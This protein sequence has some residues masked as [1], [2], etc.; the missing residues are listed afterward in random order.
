MGVWKKKWDFLDQMTEKQN[1][2]NQKS[3]EL[4]WALTRD[5][6]LAVEKKDRKV[7]L[8]EEKILTAESHIKKA[9][10]KDKQQRL[11]KKAI[12]K[13]IQ[14]KAA[15]V[16][17]D[18]AKMKEKK[19]IYDEMNLKSKQASRNIVQLKRNIEKKQK[20]MKEV[21][22]EIVK[23]KNGKCR[24]YEEKRLA[25]ANQRKK[26]T[27]EIVSLNAQIETSANHLTHLNADKRSKEH[28][29]QNAKC[30]ANS[31]K[32]KIQQRKKDISRLESG[33]KNK[34]AAFGEFM[35]RLVDE[36]QRCKKFNKKPIGP[37]GAFISLKENLP[38]EMNAVLEGELGG[39]MWAF[40][41][42]SSKD[43]V[44]LFDICKRLNISN[45]V[46]IMTS[47]FSSQQYNVSKTKVCSSSYT[48][49]LDCMEISN[50]TVFNILVDTLQLEKII[51]ISS[52]AEAQKILKNPET[53]PKNLKYAVVEAKYQYY[54][55]P[56]YKS[57]YKGYRSQNMLMASFDDLIAGI[58]KEVVNYEKEAAAA[59]EKYLDLVN[60]A[61]SSLKLSD[62]EEKKIV[63]IRKKLTEKNLLDQTLANEEYAEKPA[64]IKLD[65]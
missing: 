15:T 12:E 3:S 52:A 27:E 1:E 44:V 61:N 8:I 39:M 14:E 49:L 30:E 7:K 41:C 4:A 55:A 13:E 45:K 24:E 51:A 31:L 46:T 34:L 43:Q 42:N 50:P 56:N 17:N 54:P 25:R 58:K 35:P 21:G 57:Y 28:A 10:D 53:V 23:Y 18:N 16:E 36:I 32:V 47:E 11:D 65:S 6:D 20:M 19:K 40:C 26:V 60:Q 64:V 48:T 22:D 63:A 59:Q 33:E 38:E 37:I 29:A 5:A 9:S 62:T 2:I